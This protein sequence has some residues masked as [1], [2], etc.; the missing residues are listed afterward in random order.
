MGRRSHIRLLL[1]ATCVW[2]GF[3]LGGLPSYYQQYS[4]TS[5]VIF[6]LVVLVPITGAVYMVFRGVKRKRRLKISLW[7][8][9]YFT[10]PLATYDWIYCGVYLGH[11]MR[12]LSRFWYL[13]VY[14]AI[15]WIVM[16]T[17]ALI[18]NYQSAKASWSDSTI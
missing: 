5:M 8:A 18:L 4:T 10:V 7:F 17:V 9:F 3:W 11:G 15:P 2:A 13:S 6:D 16:P 12:F 1:I 14:Y